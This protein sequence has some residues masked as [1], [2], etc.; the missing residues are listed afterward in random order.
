MAA[1][2]F[3]PNGITHK[4]LI[5]GSFMRIL[6]IIPPYIPSYFNAG[7]HLPLFQV[8]QY[9]RIRHGFDVVA[10][11]CSA[12][13]STWR[14]LCR[15]LMQHF[16]VAAVMNDFDAIDGFERFIEYSRELSPHTKLITFGRAS[17]QVPELFEKL[18]F[19]AVGSGGDYE[20]SVSS[21]LL[22]LRES[23]SL[24]GVRICIGKGKYRG[25]E[26]GQFL[27]S[28]SWVLPDI[29]EI[30]YDAYTQLYENDLNKFCGIPQRKELV[31][32]IARGCPVGCQFCDVPRQQGQLER[33]LSVERTVA[34]IQ[35]CYRLYPFEYV[36][37]YAPTFTLRKDW[38]LKLCDKL[39]KKH[40][41]VSWKCVTTIH[42][43]DRDLI[44][45]MA[46][47]GCVRISIGVE[48]THIGV[49]QRFLPQIK[50][51]DQQRFKNVASWCTD[52]GIELNC[53]L[54]LGI[55]GED[56]KHTSNL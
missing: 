55:P 11:D 25:G 45:T 22:Y 7:H 53:F 47:A 5:K 54:M 2:S 42:H 23:T 4:K 30:P 41:S 37:F 26:P 21:Y 20:I 13:N 15:L 39:H 6:C 8:S 35:N 50:H 33:R 3:L 36:S 31:V 56:S 29:S 10:R 9:L 27:P 49:A 24:K 48:T 19:D 51:H 18:G 32:P 40:L 28:E 14:D 16:D 44:R 34:Y 46:D 43:L 38:V 52:V 1:N 12:L 17:K